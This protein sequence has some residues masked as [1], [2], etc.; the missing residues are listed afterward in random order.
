M[1]L[2]TDTKKGLVY[3]AQDKLFSDEVFKAFVVSVVQI[4][5]KE[6]EEEIITGNY[7]FSVPISFSLL[8]SSPKGTRA[9][10]PLI[11]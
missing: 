2:S 3:F 8:R 4:I 6:K 7:F 11:N 10:L 5:L 9:L 1:E